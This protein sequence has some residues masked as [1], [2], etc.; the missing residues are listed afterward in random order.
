MHPKP[1]R[2]LRDIESGF[3][4]RLVDT[5]PL[6]RFDRRRAL[7]QADLSIAFRTP[8][9][10]F[11]IV[12]V[13]RLSQVVTSTQLDRLDRGSD[14]GVSRQYKISISGSCA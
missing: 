14:A 8:K 11:D 7:G 9:R 12:C 3:G 5:L 10:S 1:P 4:E 13:G 6:Q 2:G